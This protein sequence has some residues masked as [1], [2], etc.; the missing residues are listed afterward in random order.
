MSPE[1]STSTHDEI[2]GSCVAMSC[3]D[4]V[5]LILSK[6]PSG[7]RAGLRRGSIVYVLNKSGRATEYRLN[8]GASVLLLDQPLGGIQNIQAAVVLEQTLCS[9]DKWTNSFGEWVETRVPVTIQPGSLIGIMGKRFW[10][11]K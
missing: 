6:Y 3:E 9:G 11:R 5:A 1:S 10:W 7:E 8:Q 2:F 4:R